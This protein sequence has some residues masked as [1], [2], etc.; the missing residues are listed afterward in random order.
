MPWHES[1]FAWLCYSALVSLLVLTAGS[2]AAMSCRQ[3]VRRLRIIGL[4]FIGCLAVPWLGWIPGYPQLPLGSWGRTWFPRY[5]TQDAVSPTSSEL[6][7]VGPMPALLDR[8]SQQFSA[9]LRVRENPAGDRRRLTLG[10]TE[11]LPSAPE[12]IA[13]KPDTA[14]WIC[15]LDIGQWI[16]GL[17][18]L[19]VML[20]VAW[21]LVGMVG[22]TR[23]LWTAQ[24]ASS[25]CREMLSRLA[26]RRADRVRLLTSR[27]AAQPFASMWAGRAVIVLP[28]SLCGDA[29]A[30]RWALA[31]E[32]AHIERHD[33]R[34][35]F[36][37]GLVRVLVF[38]QPL[39]WWLR[40]QLRLCQDYVADACASRQ[41]PAPEDYAEFLTHR[42][43][44]G[45]L[46]PAIV[47]LGMG[48]RK[49]ELFRRVIMLVEN[50]PIESRVSRLWTFCASLSAMVLVATVA[51]LSNAPQT[52]ADNEPGNPNNPPPA[53][54]TEKQTAADKSAAG[55]ATV[56]RQPPQRLVVP[57]DAKAFGEGWRQQV[58]MPECGGHCRGDVFEAW[59][60]NGWLHVQRLTA[61][62][63]LDWHVIL[64]KVI[65]SCQPVIAIVEG[66]PS[67]ELSYAD[68]RYLVRDNCEVLRMVRQRKAK[69]EC[70]SCDDFFAGSLNSPQSRGYGGC[71]IGANQLLLSGW[72][73]Q[74]W[75][76]SASGTDES[77][78]DCVVRLDC[79]QNE[80]GESQGCSFEGTIGVARLDHGNTWALDDGELF[81][82]SRM[83]QW[84][85]ERKVVRENIRKNL[86]G[87]V[88]P[89][90]DATKWLNTDKTTSWDAL[91]GKVILLDFWATW[92]SPCVAK[93]PHTQELADK[94]AD[95]G[96]LV[97][98]VHSSQNSEECE[99]FV[100]EHHISFPVAIDTGKTQEIF[101]VDGI[102]SY[103]LVDRTGKVAAAYLHEPPSEEVIEGLLK[104]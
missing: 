81:A 88:V 21:W 1:L 40:R 45:S 8:Q 19:G 69:E 63:E 101:A 54:N 77:H 7:P 89:P 42:A 61:K 35:W 28:E 31:H 12:A 23:I 48:F 13:T 104:N 2:A 32:W 90:I 72:E 92:C 95:R 85:Y 4:T 67:F 82:A 59:V 91:N 87:S 30:V 73:T 53:T 38:Y 3:P 6:S 64:A 55:N 97:L 65:P 74:N 62:G 22:L 14:S 78:F 17:Y 5:V 50:P 47:G 18:T 57:V 86:L 52:L 75:F 11:P 51:A 68:G 20:G 93:L 99:A 25:S 10:G 84:T 76:F 96:L 9:P 100:K 98:G 80:K 102:P 49:S 66:Q 44:A 70:L 24:P 33:F 71:G 39:V 16:V 27:R 43:A 46:H 58:P 34:A 83:L 37:A 79:M 26:G 94:Y 103:I 36:V 60:Q 29:Q 15:A 41:A 56:A